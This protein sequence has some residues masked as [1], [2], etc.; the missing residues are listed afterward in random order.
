VDLP[1]FFPKDAFPDADS[2]RIPFLY[3]F[4]QATGNIHLLLLSPPYGLDIV[5]GVFAAS[6]GSFFKNDNCIVGWRT[7]CHIID[8]RDDEQG[9]DKKQGCHAQQLKG[10]LPDLAQAEHTKVRKEQYR[11]QGGGHGKPP[12]LFH[13]DGFQ[14]N[15]QEK[16][17][18]DIGPEGD[19]DVVFI[20]FFPA[21]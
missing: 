20:T 14:K 1:Q 18:Q 16:H 19:S 21:F 12:V 11:R 5:M 2:D 8:R 4:V 7:C 10:M 3:G 9:K 13:V 15:K 17:T 6:I